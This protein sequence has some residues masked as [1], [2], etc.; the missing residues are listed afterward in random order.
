MMK[1]K[2]DGRR[3]ARRDRRRSRFGIQRMLLIS[4]AVFTGFTMLVLGVF[5][6]GLL[7]TFYRSIRDRSMNIAARQIEQA[8][9]R[10]GSI[11]DAVYDLAEDHSLCVLLFRVQ[12]DMAVA[13]TSAEVSNDC[14]I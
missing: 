13:V 2:D 12:G 6:V 11:E 9:Y 5:Q 3:A 1:K 14:I 7:D 10:E 8:L 4:L